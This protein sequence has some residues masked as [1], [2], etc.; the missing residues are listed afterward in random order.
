MGNFS[1]RKRTRGKNVWVNFSASK[2]NGPGASISIQPVKG[3]TFNYKR[4]RGFKTT[5]SI[6]GTGIRWVSSTAKKR[7]PRNVGYKPRKITKTE[8]RAEYQRLTAAIESFHNDYFGIIGQLKEI[9]QKNQYDAD[10]V[11]EL[12]NDIVSIRNEE[13][14]APVIAQLIEYMREHDDDVNIRLNEYEDLIVNRHRVIS[15]NSSCYSLL[16]PDEKYNKFDQSS[17]MK[18]KRFKDMIITTDKEID[19]RRSIGWDNDDLIFLLIRRTNYVTKLKRLVENYAMSDE[20]RETKERANSRFATVKN[21]INCLN[22]SWKRLAF[23]LKY[24]HV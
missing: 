16:A 10:R 7:A 5:L 8:E 22:N 9:E 19:Y 4:G 24:N 12:N 18:F 17:K 2:K 1:F 21:V 3:V 14:A 13:G 15:K 11:G 23:K 20:E 6:K